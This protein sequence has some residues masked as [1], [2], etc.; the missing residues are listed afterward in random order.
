MVERFVPIK[1][2]DALANPAGRA[3]T[4]ARSR[5]ALLAVPGVRDVR[6]G[7]AADEATAASWDLVLVVVFDRLEDVEPY[8][9]HPLHVAY[10]EEFLAPRT[11]FRKA[12]NFRFDAS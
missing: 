3:E 10:V 8:R 7:I 12:W 1:L 11:A 9:V 6:V 5:E 2:V 4:A